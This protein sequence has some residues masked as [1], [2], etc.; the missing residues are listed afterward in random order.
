MESA[1]V[2]V[3]AT[4]QPPPGAYTAGT[5]ADPRHAP[6]QPDAGDCGTVGAHASAGIYAALRGEPVTDDALGG[7]NS[8]KEG[9]GKEVQA[10]AI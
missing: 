8:G 1:S 6:P 3:E 9:K 2:P 7:S 10:Q 5:E 4:A